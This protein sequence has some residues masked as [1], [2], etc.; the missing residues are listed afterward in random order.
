[1]DSGSFNS[2]DSNSTS[3]DSE[4]ADL[5]LIDDTIGSEGRV[6]PET[7]ST[8]SPESA[9]EI[10]AIDDE[11]VG[12]TDLVDVE[13]NT[14]TT[15]TVYEVRLVELSDE[16]VALLELNAAGDSTTMRSVSESVTGT[17]DWFS[18]SSSTA[19]ASGDAARVRSTEPADDPEPPVDGDAAAV[20]TRDGAD[21]AGDGGATAPPQ[22]AIGFPG[23][24]GDLPGNPAGTGAIVG[25]VGVVAAVAVRQSGALSGMAGSL[26]RSAGTM[27]S[28]APGSDSLDRLVRT[29]APFRYS[30]YD[31]S[32]PLEH[33]AREEMFAVVEESPGTYLSEIAERA[34]IPLSTARHHIRVLERE[35]LVS[36]AKVRGKRRFYPAHTDGVELAAAMNDDSTAAVI[37]ALARLGAASVSDLADELDKDPSTVTH[38]VQRLEE[39]DVVV[40]ERDGRAVM[41]KLSAA[42]R[43]MLNPEER[44]AEGP[45]AGEAMASD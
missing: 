1:S 3:S 30:R 21:G 27:M 41:N 2:S 14:S 23:S 11:T 25:L 35:E 31:D 24:P 17:G 45:A 40:R 38:H 32:D 19:D 13:T 18:D 44:T 4:A 42:A 33:E 5:L 7:L 12:E 29:L 8:V 15:E 16:Q 10:T 37:D 20:D 26:G 39:D 22:N 34:D 43:T 36:G 28:T 9:R 6:L